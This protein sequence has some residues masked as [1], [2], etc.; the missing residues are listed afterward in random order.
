MAANANEPATKFWGPNY[1]FVKS[2]PPSLVIVQLHNLNPGQFWLPA[3]QPLI[4]S[5]VTL[6]PIPGQQ[7]WQHFTFP[8]VWD[9]FYRP[10]RIQLDVIFL[11]VPAP[12]FRISISFVSDRWMLNEIVT[13]AGTYSLKGTATLAWKD[14]P[15]Q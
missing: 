5:S 7:R 14:V 3:Q 10:D 8:F 4:E 1:P 11:P 2:V 15:R 13:G 9:W 12:V 6:A